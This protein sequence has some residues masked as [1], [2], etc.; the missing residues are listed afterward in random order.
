M[1]KF[2]YIFGI[3]FLATTILSG[4][5]QYYSVPRSGEGRIDRSENTIFW[6]N[7]IFFK[8]SVFFSTEEVNIRANRKWWRMEGQ[9]LPKPF[10]A[11]GY[12]TKDMTKAICLDFEFG[13]T[14]DHFC[15]D[16]NLQNGDSQRFLDVKRQSA[17]QFLME[18]GLN[19]PL[20]A[21]PIGKGKNQKTIMEDNKSMCMACPIFLLD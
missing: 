10:V 17:T 13:G 4:Q 12:L 20:R 6:A 9:E 7:P 5:S 8:P 2:G 18:A 14:V 21:A 1:Q 19:S 15:A 16:A 3:L 11:D